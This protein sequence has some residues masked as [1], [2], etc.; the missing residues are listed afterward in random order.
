M[1]DVEKNSHFYHALHVLH[2]ALSRLLK[3]L[4]IYIFNNAP[5][6]LHKSCK[7]TLKSKLQTHNDIILSLIK[8]KIINYHMINTFLKWHVWALMTSYMSSWSM[9][10]PTS[11]FSV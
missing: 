6:S 11:C 1:D 2:D 7:I 5:K 8:I 9:M 4:M 3:I 10:D